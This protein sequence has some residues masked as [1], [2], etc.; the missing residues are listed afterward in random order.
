MTVQTVRGPVGADDLGLVLPHEHLL[1]NEMREQR[2][3]GLVNDVAM[4][5]AELVGFKAAGG[6]TLVD[7]TTASLVDGAEPDPAGAMTPGSRRAVRPAGT[8][9]TASSLAVLQQMSE[10]SDVH[11]IVGA[12]QYREPYLDAEWVNRSTVGAIAEQF[13]SEV[14]EGIDGSGVRAGIIGEIAS[15]GWYVSALEERCFRAAGRA[16]AATG[17]AVTTHA[18][19]WPV[20]LAQLDLL[21]AE[22]ADPTRVIVGHCDSLNMPDYH[23]AIARRGAY[24]EFDSIR[25]TNPALVDLRVDFVMGLLDAGFSDQVLLSGDNCYTAHFHA[26]GGTGFDYLPTGF[27]QALLD[28]GVDAADVDRMMVDNPRRALTAS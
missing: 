28:R 20:G 19:R 8:T 13:I 22:G 10:A 27:R 24:V 26:G 12:G 16:Q 21:E 15:D 6:G 1:I 11:I 5:T 9:R 14:E 25:G 18:A 7:V 2:N 3:I 4:L 17:V 23:L